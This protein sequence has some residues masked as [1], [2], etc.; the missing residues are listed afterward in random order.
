M[1]AY[2]GELDPAEIRRS[3]ADAFLPKPLKLAELKE[4]IASMVG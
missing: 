4:R 1:S 2:G 3:G